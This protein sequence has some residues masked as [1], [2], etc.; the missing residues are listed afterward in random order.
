MGCCG[1]KKQKIPSES[2]LHTPEVA[3]E[4]NTVGNIPHETT[5]NDTPNKS[6]I[7]KEPNLQIISHEL[8]SM[9]PRVVLLTQG[10]NSGFKSKHGRIRESNI[11]T[12]GDK[13]SNVS[14]E[15]TRQMRKN[16][17]KESDDPKLDQMCKKHD[18]LNTKPKEETE[19]QA[20]AMK[21]A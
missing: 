19:N 11:G 21:L 18:M 7:I 8:P 5:S 4:P 12:I 20:K 2:P 6:E 9:I 14:K 16:C 13:A 1:S 15:N 17:K 10:V 3:K